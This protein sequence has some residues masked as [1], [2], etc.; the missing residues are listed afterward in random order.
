VAGREGEPAATAELVKEIGDGIFR[1]EGTGRTANAYL[2]HAQDPVVI[3]TGTPTGGRRIADEL[4]RAGIV[5]VLILLTHSHFDHA[6]GA[7]ALR[8]AT[9]APLCAPAAERRLFSGELRHRL[10]A[11]AGARAANHGRR[12]ELPAVDRWLEPGEL[13][14]GLEVVPTPGH[15][16]GH[17]SYRLGTTI[18]AGDAFMTGGRFREAVPFFIADRAESRR[19]IEKL[20]RLDLDLA[21]SGHGPPKRGA[22]EKLEALAASWSR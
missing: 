8:E 13:V 22:R 16:P 21:V 17:T 4:H 7:G 11:R 19:S 18:I 15:T 12:V 10:L 20:A 1:L 3:D 5:P 6:A 9:G 14:E 2:V